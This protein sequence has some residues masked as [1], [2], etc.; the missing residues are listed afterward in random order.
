MPSRVDIKGARKLKSKNKAILSY[1]GLYFTGI[2]FLASEKNDEF[3][4]KS[5]AQSIVL[6]LIMMLFRNFFLLIP[7]IGTYLTMLFDIIFI[8]LLVFLILKASRNI[9]FRLPIISEISEKYVINW[10]KKS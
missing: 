6:S 4:R 10:F 3:V 9:Y 2:L 1:I 8:I 7:F 5:A